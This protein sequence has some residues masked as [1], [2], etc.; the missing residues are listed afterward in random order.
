MKIGFSSDTYEYKELID[1]CTSYGKIEYI[2]SS[3]KTKVVN[4]TNQLRY[5]YLGKYVYLKVND[6]VANSSNLKLIFIVRNKQY[7]YV[8]K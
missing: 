1:F 5:S 7:T 4:M 2:D 3:N 8:I 6:D